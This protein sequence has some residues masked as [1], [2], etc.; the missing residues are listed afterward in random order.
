MTPSPWWRRA[1]IYEL[2]VQNFDG[3]DG[4]GIGDLAGVRARLP[5]LAGLGDDAIWSSPGHPSPRSGAGHDGA[6]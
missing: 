5:Y 2:F 3:G 6:D 1:A 4:D